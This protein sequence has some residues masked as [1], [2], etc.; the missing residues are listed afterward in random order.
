MNYKDH[1]EEQ[2][3]PIPKE[4]LVFSKFPSCVVGPSSDLPLPSITEQLD[5][6]VELCIVVGKEVKNI[7]KEDAMDCVFGFTAAH[8]VSARDWQLKRYGN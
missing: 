6:E 8:D 7:S 2:G 3:V 5:W 1:C 4:P